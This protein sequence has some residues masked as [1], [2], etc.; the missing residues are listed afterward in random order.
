MIVT[1]YIESLE[2]SIEDLAASIAA[3]ASVGAWTAIPGLDTDI[4]SMYAAKVF[5]INKHNSKTA[6]I[7]V[8][9]PM[10]LF[11]HD[12]IPQILADIAGN[13]FGLRGLKN[14]RV[15]DLE[16][17]EHLTEVHK[18]PAFGIQGIKDV[19]KI[20]D[21][22][23]LSTI[24]K[25]KVG[26]PT[27]KFV[28][29]AIEAW[30]G[31]ADIVQDDDKL[32]DQDFNPFYDR[33]SLMIEARRKA[34]EITGEIK[35]YF[36]N[37]SARMSEMYAR[38]KYIREMGGRGMMVDLLTVGFSGLQFLREQELGL[39][40]HGHRSMHG[41]FTHSKRHGI[42]M[43]VF[44]KLARLA[45]VDQL[46]TGTV[47]G[48][49]DTKSEDI[50]KVDEFLQKSWFGLKP[51]MPI[52]SGGLHP[53]LIPELVSVLGKDIIL[54]IGGGINGHPNGVRSGAKAARQAIDASMAQADIE[55]YAKSNPELGEA[56][57]FWPKKAE[58]QHRTYVHSLA[59]TKGLNLLKSD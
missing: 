53:R 23:I 35:I 3:E 14:L 2:A 15:K 26:L 34:E 49:I 28:E 5:S 59:L 29:I 4:F 25:P 51:T 46:H 10:G 1:Y 7:K 38:G 41:A 24:I 40:I 6:T 31:G 19:L 55:E 45:G 36:P 21:R 8:A 16:L 9:F 52:E 20:Q 17:P 12:N 58:H 47:T 44:A 30:V 56:L 57:K 27:R 50:E 32:T 42:A 54:N 37:V 33:V 48:N 18:G 39:I 43:I 11:E 22:P 13:V